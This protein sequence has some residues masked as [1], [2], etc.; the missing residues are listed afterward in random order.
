MPSTG[1]VTAPAGYVPRQAISFGSEGAA[2][3]AVDDSNPLPVRP[4]ASVG[5]TSTPL[6]ATTTASGASAAF[7][8]QLS[9]AIWLTLSG[10]WTGS[11]T[12]QRS[13]DAG[14]TWNALTYGDGSARPA[15][16]ANMQATI[17]EET[18][19]GATYRLLITITSGSLS[20]RMEQ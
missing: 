9:R 5:A 14:A 6:A 16:T 13:T 12:L 2:A 10:V 7:A 17:A 18:V 8:P 15:W 1:T 20:Y 19:A 3:I 11:V 4:I